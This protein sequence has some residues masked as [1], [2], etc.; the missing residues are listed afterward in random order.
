MKAVCVGARE[1]LDRLGCA[2]GIIPKREGTPVRVRHPVVRVQYTNLVA[3]FFEFQFVDDL[4][5]A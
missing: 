3:E 4:F 1:L 5:A 2:G